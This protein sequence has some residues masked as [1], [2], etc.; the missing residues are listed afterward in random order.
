MA[1]SEATLVAVTFNWGTCVIASE[2]REPKMNGIPEKIHKSFRFFEKRKTKMCGNLK[3][4]RIQGIEPWS[5]P[6][7][8]TMIPLHQMRS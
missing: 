8:G 4:L 7:E 1:R 3:L 2:N 5:V 6:W